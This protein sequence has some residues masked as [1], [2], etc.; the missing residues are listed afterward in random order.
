MPARDERESPAAA[1]KGS[2]HQS[3]SSLAAVDVLVLCG[4]LGSRLRSIIPD[5]P[6][7]LAPVAGRPFMDI[8]IEDLVRQGFR[9]IIFCVGHLKEQIIG[10]YGSRTDAEYLFSKEDV[11]LGTGGAVQNALSLVRSDTFLVTNGDSLCRVDYRKF[12]KFHLDNGAIVSMVLAD[13]PDREDGGNVCLDD[14]HRI[15]SFAEKSPTGQQDR[16]INAGIY[17]MRRDEV[18]L[19][20]REVPFSLEYDLFPAMIKAKPCFGF[21]VESKL[22]DIGTPAGFLKINEHFLQ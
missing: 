12:Y 16:F 18:E 11:A 15:R 3:A 4:G 13:V 6:K 10:S 1:G 14:R 8:L 5:R 2:D 22:F 7:G 21:V 19:Q 17:L 9:R 20:N